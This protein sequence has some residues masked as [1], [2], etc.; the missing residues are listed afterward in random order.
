MQLTFLWIPRDN[1]RNQREH[2]ILLLANSHIRL[3][4]KPEPLNKVQNVL[5]CANHAVLRICISNILD[6]NVEFTN[7]LVYLY[8]FLPGA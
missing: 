6:P 7:S 2:L 8:D 3:H 1:V 4:P 5:V